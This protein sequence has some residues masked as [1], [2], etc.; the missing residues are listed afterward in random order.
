[1]TAEVGILSRMGVALA[2][3]SAVSVGPRAQ[4]IYASAD[5]LFQLANAAPVGVMI[6]GG[7]ALLGLPWETLLKACRR[8]LGGKLLPRLEDY[9][10]GLLAFLGE[11]RTFFTAEAQARFV[12]YETSEF[13]SSFGDRLDTALDAAM[14]IKGE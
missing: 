8:R 11:V 5:K 1:M 6:Y 2:A 14:R 7:A 4:K 9:S 3:D 13:L 12:E 10:D